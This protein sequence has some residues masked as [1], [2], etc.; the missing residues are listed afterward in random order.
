MRYPLVAIVIAGMLFLLI[1]S[2]GNGGLQCAPPYP[3]STVS[4]S[5]KKIMAVSDD[6]E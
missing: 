5:A 2:G 1:I 6:M 4:V 3:V